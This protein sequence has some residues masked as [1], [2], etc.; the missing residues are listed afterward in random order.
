MTQQD[1]RAEVR[2]VGHAAYFYSFRRF[3]NQAEICLCWNHQSQ[4]HRLRSKI[5]Y[6]IIK[7]DPEATAL[8]LLFSRRDTQSTKQICGVR[9]GAGKSRVRT[10]VCARA[11]MH[12]LECVTYSVCDH[13]HPH[14]LV[15]GPL[16]VVTVKPQVDKP[17][18]PKH[19]KQKSQFVMSSNGRAAEKR[20]ST[21]QEVCESS[22][23][24]LCSSRTYQ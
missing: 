22:P 9:H 7:N 2:S 24:C 18:A 8:T 5:Q 11:G 6:P 14:E 21:V 16:D 19:I 12:A 1:N 23:K 20:T 10:Y 4:I 13:F 3:T 15:L 17:V